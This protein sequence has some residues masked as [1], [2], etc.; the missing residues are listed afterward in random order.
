MRWLFRTGLLLL[1]TWGFFVIS[2]FVA[3]YDLAEAVKAKDLEAIEER[4]NFRA[5]RI[6]LSRQIVVEYL[7]A[8]G[9]GHEL[10]GL[11]RRLASGAGATIADPLVARLVTPEALVD[12]LDDG[13]PQGLT[14]TASPASFELNFTSLG[15]AIRVFA[16]SETRGF[17]NVY[18]A[19]PDDR[20]R[21]ERFKFHLRLSGFTWRL[22]GIELPA[23][24][25]RELIKQLPNGEAPSKA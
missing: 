3:L 11:D 21:E 24:L 5:V 6:S 14:G 4:V 18:V 23:T 13:A 2:P 9:R 7:N 16:Q 10:D 19:W 22:T 17:R 20:P 25:R 15:R 8:V 1:L 12:L